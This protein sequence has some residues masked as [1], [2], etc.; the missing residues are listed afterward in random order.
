M[1][2]VTFE[3]QDMADFRAE[4]PQF[5]GLSDQVL[6]R[7]YWDACELVGNR[8][9]S[10]V[11]YS[12]PAVITRR[13]LIFLAMC[14]LAELESRAAQGIDGAVTNA[15]EGT[16][17]V[18]VTL[19]QGRQGD[20]WWNLTPYGQQF[21]QMIAPYRTGFFYFAHREAHPFV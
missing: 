8:E 15:T 4:R 16:V 14:H 9:D 11:P 21:A 12:P 20:A 13:R 17:S 5:A 1:A 7:L 19:P 10:L 2:L 6:Q 18:G 3:A